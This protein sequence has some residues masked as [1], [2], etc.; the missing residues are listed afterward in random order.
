MDPSSHI[1][2]SAH[3]S[4]LRATAQEG[5]PMTDESAFM[6]AILADP[7]NIGLRLAY[8]DWLEE[9]GG[10]K[11]LR[12]ARYIRLECELDGLPPEDKRRPELET[13]LQALR[14]T[15]GHDWWRELD[16]GSV[17]YCVEVRFRCPQ[18]WDT[19]VATED[20]KVRHCTECRK[21]VHYART[22]RDAYDLA[23]AGE[24]VAI[25]SRQLQFPPM[26]HSDESGGLLLGLLLQVRPQRIPLKLRGKP[27]ETE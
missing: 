27:S 9:T 20:P 8:A 5:K 2:G 18:R 6:R 13:G 25:D 17:H 23:K 7:G 3:S 1:A 22:Q 4:H 24:C 21:D 16:W 11:F 10:A 19:L 14:G 12:R 26:D 15:I